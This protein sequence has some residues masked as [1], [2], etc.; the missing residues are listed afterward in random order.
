MI[1]CMN[2]G[3]TTYRNKAK[4]SMVTSL[5]NTAPFPEESLTANSSSL[6]VGA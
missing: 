5:K 1:A 2:K 6:R 3:S 4:L